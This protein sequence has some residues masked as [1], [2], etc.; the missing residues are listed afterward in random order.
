MTSDPFHS[1]EAGENAVDLVSPMAVPAEQEVEA[2]LRPKSL[3][4]FVGQP[5]VREQLELVL[6]SA[7]TTCCCPARPGWARPAWP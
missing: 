5:K 3:T 7:R 4:D 1:V 2:S 6:A